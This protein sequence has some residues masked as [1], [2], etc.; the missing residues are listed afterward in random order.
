MRNG[1]WQPRWLSGL[2]LGAVAAA[3]GGLFGYYVGTGVPG[4]RPAP[5]PRISLPAGEA[6]GQGV[7]LS[8][9]VTTA[10]RAAG[11]SVV[12][13]AVRQEGLVDSFFGQIPTEQEGVGSGVIID[14]NGLILTNDHVVAGATQIDVYLP[15][16]RSFAGRF[17]GN[18]PESDLAVIKIDEGGLPAARLGRSADLL[19]GQPVIAIG[20]PLGFDYTVTTGVVSALGRQLL[21]E[22]GTERPLENLIQTD[23]AI[24]P[25]N[26]GGPLVDLEGRVV[27]INTAIVR[28][29]QGFEVQG[30][31]FA[32]PIDQARQIAT[33]I[34]T[35]GKPLR[36][37]VSAGTLTPA[38]ARAIER[39]TGRALPVQEGVFVTRVTPGSAADR[40]GVAAADVIVRAGGRTVRNVSDLAAAVQEAGFNG[41]LALGLYRGNRRLELRARLP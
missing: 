16:G 7:S 6:R 29:V 8:E 4:G 25:G 22:S 37:G 2:A 18:D 5:A 38:I 13:I 20:N 36:L 24:N 35:Y 34:A 10:V 39:A 31:G 19:V 14:A 33:Q 15:D 28:R 3:I 21:V 12:K 17:I 9:D 30:L 23:A 32:I 27:G 26:S 41:E 11:P 1:K 40:A